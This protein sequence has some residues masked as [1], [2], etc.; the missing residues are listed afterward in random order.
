MPGSGELTPFEILNPDAVYESPKANMKSEE[1]HGTRAH[2]DAAKEVRATPTRH[3]D[4]DMVSC[5][6]ELSDLLFGTHT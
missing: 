1:F 5:C 6:G 4:M 2:V 3:R